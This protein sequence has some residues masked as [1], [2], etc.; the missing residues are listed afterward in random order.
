MINLQIYVEDFQ[1]LIRK[2]V[3]PLKSDIVGKTIT[4]DKNLN[5]E[6]NYN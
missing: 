3:K 5:V 6:V 4:D 2:D 1:E